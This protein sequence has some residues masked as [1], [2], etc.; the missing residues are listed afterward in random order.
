MIEG[1]M[2]ASG[3]DPYADALNAK[4]LSKRIAAVTNRTIKAVPVL[5]ADGAVLLRGRRR[6]DRAKDTTD[7]RSG[8]RRIQV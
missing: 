6:S 2:E 4:R 1:D 3:S 8:E 5:R 7:R